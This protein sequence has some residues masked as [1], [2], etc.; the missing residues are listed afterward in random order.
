MANLPPGAYDLLVTE[1]LAQEIQLL[2]SRGVHVTTERLDPALAVEPMARA[3]SGLISRKLEDRARRYESTI[4]EVTAEAN[5]ALAASAGY[6]PSPDRMTGDRLVSVGTSQMR[7]PVSPIVPLSEHC[8]ITGDRGEAPLGQQL[9]QEIESSDE[10]DLLCSFIKWSGLQVLVDS[11]RRFC[12]RPGARL[13]V[14]TTTYIGATEQCAVEEIA[15]LPNTEVRIS[16]G[17]DGTRLHAKSWILRRKSGFGTCFVGSA[18]ISHPALTDGLEWTLRISQVRERSLWDKLNASFET[19]WNDP[20]FKRFQSGNIT[21]SELLRDALARAS[22][23]NAD[24]LSESIPAYDLMPKD[25]QSE[26]LERLDRERRILGRTRQLVVAATGTGKT[27]VAAFDF[28]RFRAD[29]ARAVNGRPPRLLYLVHREE[30]LKQALRSFRGVLRRADFGCLLSGSSRGDEDE[31]VFATIQSFRSRGLLE[32]LGPGHWDYVVLDEAH[33]AEAATYREVLQQLKPQI[34]LGLTATPER[35]D[36]LDITQYFEG[37]V[38]AEVRLPDAI[39]RRLLV[40]FHYFVA[41]DDDSIQLSNIA[42]NRG[43]YDAGALDAMYNGNLARAML[44]EQELRRRVLD[45]RH[46]RA[47]GFCAGIR[48][49]RYMAE[50]FETKFGIPA[51]ALTGEDAVAERQVGINKLRDRK[52]NAI[53]TADLF[54]EGVDIPEVDTV[55]FLRPTESL[56]VFLQQLGRG[57]RRSDFKEALTV[58]D[59][60]ANTDRRYRMDR[61]FRALLARQTVDLEKECKHR[62]PTLPAGCAIS[63][64]REAQDRVLENIRQYA[65]PNRKVVLDEI[66]R[67]RTDHGRAPTL[68]E[69]LSTFDRDVI[70]VYQR[71]IWSSLREEAGGTNPTPSQADTKHVQSAM[72]RMCMIDDRSWITTVRSIIRDARQGQWHP[73]TPLEHLHATMLG[74]TLWKDAEAPTD[75]AELVDRLQREPVFTEELESLLEVASDRISADPVTISLGFDH[76]LTLHAQYTLDQ[77][78]SALGML[79]RNQVNNIREGVKFDPER[80]VYL[81]FVT[82]NKSEADYSESTRYQDYAVSATHFHWQTQNSAAPHSEGGMRIIDHRARGIKLLLFVRERNTDRNITVPYVFLG[83]FRYESHEGSKPMSVI[84]ELSHPIP[85]AMLR[86]ALKAG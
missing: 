13:R 68:R 43:R 72:K 70:D 35:A 77:L 8:L 1:Q 22:G 81:M 20:A 56:T 55:M 23:K 67:F 36:G 40:P 42:F 18:N 76:A 52:V 51:I 48:H 39:E 61:K 82:L 54:N 78:L 16:Y 21:D 2:L 25:F 85:A 34:L 19:S 49:A 32:R 63:L 46:M 66:R 30:I 33:H 75:V 58:L 62:F 27:M 12:E 29:P 69:Y 9:Q 31:N 14:L 26:I 60:V 83:E 73:S 79:S 15:R 10:I 28:R 53:F 86:S 5:S 59:F 6:D 3:I 64:D 38:S 57:L 37:S 4:D 44:I 65:Q 84:G 80:R 7:G 74:R 24:R 71:G 17:S 11:L 45:V 41:R 50:V 47:L